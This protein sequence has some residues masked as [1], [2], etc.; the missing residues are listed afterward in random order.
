MGGRA[1]QVLQFI[2][3]WQLTIFP[4]IKFGNLGTIRATSYTHTWPKE[5]SKIENGRPREL[6]QG[7][8][9]LVANLPRTTPSTTLVDVPHASVEAREMKNDMYRSGYSNMYP[10]INTA[11]SH[12]GKSMK[13]GKP[14]NSLLLTYIV[15]SLVL[16]D[17]L[18]F[19]IAISMWQDR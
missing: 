2:E 19:W 14:I 3:F 12:C 7:Q 17:K 10:N 6:V 5:P 18:G 11:Q 8:S 1:V 9:I 4:N 16:M 13:S 15:Q